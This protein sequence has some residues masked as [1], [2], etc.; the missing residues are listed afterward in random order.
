MK[1]SNLLCVVGVLSIISGLSL[2]AQNAS[3][4]TNGLAAYY[5]FDGNANDES[6]NGQ[7]NNTTTSGVF[8]LISSNAFPANTWLHIT[9]TRTSSQLAIFV[10]GR[11]E[12]TGSTTGPNDYSHGYI[13]KVG[14]NS[15]IDF[16]AFGGKIDDIRF[17]NRA[18]SNEEVSELF[19]AESIALGIVTLPTVT[20]Q[21]LQPT[22]DK[23]YRIEYKDDVS[24]TAWTSLVTNIVLTNTFFLYPDTSALNQP[25]R[26]YRLVAE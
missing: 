14:G 21:R 12:G 2:K 3:F 13:P 16:D 22:I 5:P 15:G 25:K 20:I 8:G 9:Y 18:L 11:L 6:G 23:T 19:E 17:Y 24:V 26:F 4:L 1:K 10:N 7:A